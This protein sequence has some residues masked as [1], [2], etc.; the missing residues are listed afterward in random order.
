MKRWL[1]ALCIGGLAASALA[2]D[3]DLK[4]VTPVPP[5]QAI[6][7][8]DFFRPRLISDVAL[9]PSGT[10]VAALMAVIGQDK[11]ALSTIDLGSGKTAP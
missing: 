2:A 9:N 11:I 5:D 8:Q 3:L 4:R 6:P 10:H 1:S 7:I